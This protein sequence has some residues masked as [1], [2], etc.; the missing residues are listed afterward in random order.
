[1]EA[2]NSLDFW[3]T[4][5]AAGLGFFITSFIKWLFDSFWDTANKTEKRRDHDVEELEVCVG[6]LR[7]L[8]REYWVAP[9]NELANPH[10]TEAEVQACMLLISELCARLFDTKLQVKRDLDLLINK[11][12]FEVTGGDFGVQN[13]FAQPSRL[14]GVEITAVTLSSEVKRQRRLLSRRF[15]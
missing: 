11:L 5:V 14:T 2:A 12:D 3:T 9:R 7:V 13:R 8:A 15:I 10:A 4:V 1:M 6:R